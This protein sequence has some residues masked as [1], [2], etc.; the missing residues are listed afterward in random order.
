[1][2]RMRKVVLEVQ[3]GISMGRLLLNAIC[4]SGSIGNTKKV[5]FLD[6]LISGMRETHASALPLFYMALTK[7][8]LQHTKVKLQRFFQQ[9][10]VD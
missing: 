8:R 1:M 2:R 7:K 9:I 6:Y 5:G 4:L 10:S 3:F